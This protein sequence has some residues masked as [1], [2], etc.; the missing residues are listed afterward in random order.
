MRAALALASFVVMFHPNTHVS[1]M[2]AVIVVLAT[3]YVVI[4]HRKI[5]PPKNE[6]QPQPII[7]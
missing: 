1:I 2:V 3:F 7:I 6:L 4:R 5:T